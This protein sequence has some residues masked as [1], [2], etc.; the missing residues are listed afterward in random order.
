MYTSAR[1]RLTAHLLRAE[2][3]SWAVNGIAGGSPLVGTIDPTG[4]YIAPSRVPPGGQVTIRATTA[5]GAWEEVTIAIVW[6]PRAQAAPAPRRGL[7]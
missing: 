5:S 2:A 4:L 6:A 3:L 1:V 7:R